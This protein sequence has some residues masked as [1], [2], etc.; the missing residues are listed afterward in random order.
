MPYATKAEFRTETGLLPKDISDTDLDHFL[1]LGAKQIKREAYVWVREQVLTPDQNDRY[2]FTYGGRG[3]ASIFTTIGMGGTVTG[4]FYLADSALDSSLDANDIEVYEW[5][6]TN[7]LLVDI[8]DQIDDVNQLN[9]YF[10][11]NSGYPT[12]N[13]QV[14]VTWWYCG[15]RFDEIK[16]YELKYAEIY[17]AMYLW[18]KKRLTFLLKS[19]VTSFTLGKQTVNREIDDFEKM[20]EKYKMLY[21]KLINYIKP[22]VG[23]YMRMNRGRAYQ[24]YGLTLKNPNL[25]N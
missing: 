24:G 25:Y 13:R 8:S 7:N 16:D 6:S 14:R 12:Q 23:K 15:K 3:M 10:T 4:N 18:S 9:N 11:L 21:D 19:G 2:F 17:Y 1:T 20:V 5:D 22:F